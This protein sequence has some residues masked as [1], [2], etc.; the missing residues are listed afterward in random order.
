MFFHTEK[1]WDQSYF[2]SYG[3][4]HGQVEA[5]HIFTGGE[6]AFV[7]ISHVK[8]LISPPPA[9]LGQWLQPVPAGRP[10]VSKDVTEATCGPREQVSVS[11]GHTDTTMFCP[12][13]PQIK[14]EL[15]TYCL[16]VSNT[17]KSW[18]DSNVVVKSSL[19]LGSFH[20]G[21]NCMSL[22]SLQWN[23]MFWHGDQINL[24]RT[25][26]NTK[27]THIPHSFMHLWIN[28]NMGQRCCISFVA[29]LL[30]KSNPHTQRIR[31]NSWPEDFCSGWGNGREKSTM[32]CLFS[33]R[34]V[35]SFCQQQKQ[36]I[37]VSIHVYKATASNQTAWVPIFRDGTQ[38]CLL[39]VC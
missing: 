27:L 35:V 38:G 18:G 7:K 8:W 14:L 31:L 3:Q 1:Y 2:H 34:T 30:T 28:F 20:F 16:C 22:S 10:A 26:L 24:K 23:L 5:R 6:L 39:L 17:F 21:G 9:I 29:S 37:F 15:Q 32:T 33:R 19:G 36:K 13:S 25:S 12:Q 4:R 11:Y